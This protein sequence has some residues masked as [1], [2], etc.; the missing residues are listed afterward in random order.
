MES[1]R[2]FFPEATSLNNCDCRRVKGKIKSNK[3]KRNKT[4]ITSDYP[5]APKPLGWFQWTGFRS[6]TEKQVAVGL[7]GGF[8]SVEDHQ[9]TR[10][11]SCKKRLGQH[12]LAR[13][14]SPEDSPQGAVGP[15]ASPTPTCRLICS[16]AGQPLTLSTVASSRFYEI[17]GFNLCV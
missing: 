15:L 7:P 9:V 6:G 10:F 16:L 11:V 5:V 2:K 12:G 4:F 8:S 3:T 13:A 17:S 1:S 14:R